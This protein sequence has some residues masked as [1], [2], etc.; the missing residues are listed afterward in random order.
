MQIVIQYNKPFTLDVDLSNTIYEIRKLIAEKL[1][2]PENLFM[3]IY[4]GYGL[5]DNKKTVSEYAIKAGNTIHVHVLGRG[6]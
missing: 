2:I 6:D 1:G 3:M 5:L 4:N